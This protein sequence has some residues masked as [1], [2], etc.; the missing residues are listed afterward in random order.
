[1]ND[2]VTPDTFRDSMDRC[3]S[4]INGDPFLARRIIAS[5][6][7]EKKVKLKPVIRFAI[8]LAALFVLATAAYGAATIFF[9]G[10]AWGGAGV[11]SDFT[12]FDGLDNYELPAE[13]KRTMD[14]LLYESNLPDEDYLDVRYKF[15]DGFSTGNRHE[16]VKYF[17]SQDDFRRFMEDIDYLTLPTWLPEGKITDFYASV[18]FG[19]LSDDDDQLIWNDDDKIDPKAHVIEE[20]IENGVY[21]RHCRFDEADRIVTG[22]YFSICMDEYGRFTVSSAVPN[23]I[24]LLADEDVIV[25]VS[26]PGMNDAILD[27]GQFADGTPETRLYMSRDF[28]SAR[29]G[30]TE[31]VLEQI[32]VTSQT[33]DPDLMIRMFSGK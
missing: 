12:M 27:Y 26:V 28:D 6:K 23:S 24:F 19:L 7:G 20:G 11:L 15:A 29:F 16:P 2:K 9:N 10:R 13:A 21:Y 30:M 5:G 3:F 4:D 22:Y 14:R 25:H 32:Q 1:M 8:I 18:T 31:P 17:E 33:L